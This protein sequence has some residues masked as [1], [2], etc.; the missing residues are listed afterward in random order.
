MLFACV[1]AYISLVLCGIGHRQAAAR[2]LKQTAVLAE[3]AA[4]DEEHLFLFRRTVACCAS[5]VHWRFIVCC[6]C[7]PW[8]CVLADTD[9]SPQAKMNYELWC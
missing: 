7:M 1:R 6:L 3:W 5:L 4:A 2:M 9:M 8:L